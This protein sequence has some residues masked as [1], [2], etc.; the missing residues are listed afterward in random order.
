MMKIGLVNS[1]DDLY[2]LFVN[3]R[4]R[5]SVGSVGTVGREE[6]KGEKPTANSLIF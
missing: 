4:L 5:E 2:Q 3:Q 6:D 1:R